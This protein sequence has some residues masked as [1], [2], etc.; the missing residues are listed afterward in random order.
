ML[1]PN[2][3][4]NSGAYRYGFQGQEKDDELKGDGNSLNYTF[5]MHDPRVGRF[6][7]R[8]PLEKSYPWNSP[9]AFSE[10]RVIDGK[11]L[12]GLEYYQAIDSPH[13]ADILDSFSPGFAFSSG[14]AAISNTVRKATAKLYGDTS[15]TRVTV[16]VQNY[17]DI[18][19]GAESSGT[20][21]ENEQVNMNK[22]SAKDG[23]LDIVETLG[24]AVGLGTQA[25]G[26]AK[27]AG[28]LLS[29]GASKGTII[30]QTA[31]KSFEELA[32]V[33]KNSNVAEGHFILYQIDDADEILKIGKA[34]AGRTT[35]LGDPVRM[36]ASERA[37]QKTNPNAKARIIE[38]LGKTTT[39]KAKDVEATTVKAKR[40]SGHK[41][42]LNKERDIKYRN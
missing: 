5:R 3:H 10:N 31:I 39:G 37:A 6:F 21:I 18:F 40:A 13:D 20:I 1:I 11:E 42:P 14:M 41:L 32:K 16:K 29:K 26:L 30:K 4:G 9:Y 35:A 36:R 8:D 33:N 19:S 27:G 17:V 24:N 12:E 28:V 2:R 22:A 38:D 34:D 7:A 23:V 15:Y 25:R